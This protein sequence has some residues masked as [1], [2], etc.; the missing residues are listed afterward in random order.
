M[1]KI[2]LLLSLLVVLASVGCTAGGQPDSVSA[3]PL[4]G[5]WEDTTGARIRFTEETY[6]TSAANPDLP[7]YHYTVLSS[8]RLALKPLATVDGLEVEKEDGSRV[9]GFVVEDETLRMDSL[10]SEFYRVGSQALAAA[11]SDRD[12]AVP[13]RN[14]TAEA[15]MQLDA[16]AI[17][18][19]AYATSFDAWFDSKYPDRRDLGYTAGMYM[20]YRDISIDWDFPLTRKRLARPYGRAIDAYMSDVMTDQQTAHAEF[21]RWIRA[22][23]CPSGGVYTTAWNLEMPALPR[24]TCSIHDK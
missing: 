1:R 6:F 15:K 9:V 3:N 19:T 11:L 24:I 16:C 4:V 21:S 18:R 17:V 23:I 22:G 20:R 13:D 8:G 5:E 14:N 2:L 10:S 7:R 12:K